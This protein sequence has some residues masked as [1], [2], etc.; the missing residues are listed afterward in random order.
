MDEVLEV[1]EAVRKGRGING[2]AASRG[3][4]SFGRVTTMVSFT[5]SVC[6]ATRQGKL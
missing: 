5:V 6:T 2:C 3:G 1:M 4:V